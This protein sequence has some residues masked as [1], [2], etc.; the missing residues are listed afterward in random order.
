MNIQPRGTGT[1]AAAVTSTA[2]LLGFAVLQGQ[3]APE[4]YTTWR[5][6][7][8]SADA[9]QY[10]ALRQ[11]TRGNVNRLELAWFHAAPGEPVAFNP[12][13]VDGVMYILGAERS[14]AAIDAA[15]GKLIWSHPVEGN[16]AERGI[17]YWESKDRSD[18]RLIYTSGSYLREINARTG[19]TINSFGTDGRV[20][21]REGLDRD[22]RTIRNIQSRNPGRVFENLVVLGSATG[23]GFGSPPGD[24]RAYDV[25]TGKMAW[26]FH[27]I[28]RPGE[29]GFDTWPP[30]AYKYAGGANNW[31][32]MAL[33][34]R[35]GIVYVPL[36]SPTADLYGAD[37]AGANL[38]G[39]CLVAL[40]A[41]TGKRLW[42]YQTVHHDLWD[43]DL[44]TA[45]KLLTVKHNGKKVDIVAQAAKHG[46]LFVF[47]RVT[48]RPLWP[49]EERP[50]PR[51]E[52]PGEESSHTQPFPTRPPPFSRQAFSTEEVNPF[53]EPEEQKLL[54]DTLRN[55]YNM[56]VFTPS[57][58]LRNHIQIPGAFGGSNWGAAAGD[59]ASGMLYLRIY[60]APSIRQLSERRATRAAAGNI[61]ERGLAIYIQHCS[62][63]H[64]PDKTGI[65]AP[66]DLAAFRRAVRSGRGQMPP[67]P[68]TTISNP[69]L[70][71][72]AAY[73]DNPAAGEAPP[74]EEASG[75]GGRS[76]AGP[77][78]RAASSESGD[79]PRGPERPEGMRQFSGPFGAQWLTKEGLPAIG[80]PWSEL[81]AYDL[82][83]GTINWRVPIGTV[84]LLA[85]R[86]ITNTG[87]YRPRNGPVVT[88]GGLIF[89]ASGGDHT[90]RAHDKNGGKVL[91]EKQLEANPDGIPSVYEV[92]GRQYVVFYAAG[93]KGGGS[94]TPAM[95]K[96]GKPEA[97]GY[98][99]FALP[100]KA[101]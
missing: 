43:Y 68:E 78:E 62:Q 95:F 64:G 69:N 11:I 56:G 53:V 61:E 86:G 47:D 30:D 14:I 60:D 45:P 57:S 87:S 48:G 3:S 21:L 101:P 6:Y 63:C 80:P 22:P 8:G 1:G 92:G 41:R 24:I 40:N 77:A 25:I 29:F 20:D 12:I 59:P 58:H 81:V 46:F 26:S 79:A 34:E 7:A 67:F 10:S 27:T 44:T 82:N 51:S 9:M 98:Y 74:A 84:P 37:R 93:D 49:I 100:R 72:V 32:E 4:P 99:A 91:W 17:N 55:A 54:R 70:E 19:V 50:V 5:D 35:R 39:N 83:K 38:F 23:E 36:G 73:L 90:L 2:L 13:V 88:A 28:P 75:R 89:L 76:G 94:R 42:H 71:A 33:D 96:P 85:A 97:Q 65:P 52:V 15:S 31:G 66:K 16:P 18:R